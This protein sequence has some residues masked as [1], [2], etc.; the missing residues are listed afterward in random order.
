MPLQ[1]NLILGGA[2]EGQAK[3][4]GVSGLG[5]ILAGT[6]CLM[7]L[8]ASPVRAGQSVTLSWQSNPDPEV[9]GYDIYY[10]ST[11]HDYTN[12]IDAGTNSFV[13]IS[14]LASG[15]TYYFA[16]T[17]YDAQNQQSEFSNEAIFTVPAML[18]T[19]A[20]MS[21]PTGTI[22]AGQFRLTIIG[23]ANQNYQIEAT[24]DFSA[25]TIIGT[26]LTDAVGSAGFTDTNSADFPQ[27]FYRT[28]Q[29]P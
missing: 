22:P 5:K 20:V 4:H 16:A 11:S 14:N 3:R 7:L 24:G 8:L 27:R 25:W 29:I 2:N 13:T 23:P 17:A 18:I 12:I 1:F 28:R 26:V 10:G 19:N 15:I 21:V 6:G 9:A